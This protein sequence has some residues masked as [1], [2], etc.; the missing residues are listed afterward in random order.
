MVAD[1]V[2]QENASIVG[3]INI[4][5]SILTDKENSSSN[6]KFRIGMDEVVDIDSTAEY[7]DSNSN[8]L[9]TGKIKKAKEISKDANSD[10]VI[11]EL[12]I[13]D[14]GYRLIDGNLNEV[15][16]NKEP[17]EI[18]EDVV[19]GVGLTFVNQLPAASGISISKKVYQDRDPIEAVNELCNTLGANWRVE[20]TTFYLF[21]RG[22]T[23]SSETI[24]GTSEWALNRDGWVDNTDKQAKTVI[25]KGAVITQRTAETLSGTNTV[26]TLSRTPIDIEFAGL[27]QTTENINGDYTVD[28]Q[29]K[30]V[31]FDVSQTNPEALYSYESQVRAQVGSGEPI[32]VIN[33]SY[34]EDIIEARKLGRK[35]LEIFG[36]GIQSARWINKDIYSMNLNNFIVGNKIPVINRLNT[37]R[38]GQ[39]VITKIVRKYPTQ[40]E[41]TVGE[42]ETSLYNWQSESKDRIKQLEERDQNSDFVQ[43]DVFQTGKVQVKLTAA[44]TKYLV[45]INDGKVLWA[46]DTTLSTDADLISDTGP[47]VDYAIA[48]DDSAL[49]SGSF[50]DILNP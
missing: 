2:F 36:D 21:R 39:Y 23:L 43:L 8:A 44:L 16:R 19:V 1:F 11:Y 20:G 22:Y 4:S 7:Y 49:P 12:T 48:Y 33:R 14:E 24:D 37:D 42:D 10:A 45:V 40:N 29:A 15:F 6:V 5:S 50:I 32:K 9:I 46:S 38:D 27:T 3:A 28:K 26:F 25:V 35:Y 18:I 17:E 31:T 13:F 30:E 47:D 41:I 34:I